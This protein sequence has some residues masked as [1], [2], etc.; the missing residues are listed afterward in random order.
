MSTPTIDLAF[1]KQ[2][3]SESHIAYQQKGSKLRGMV[4][5]KVHL[6]GTETRFPKYGKGSAGKK[7]R[8]GKIPVMNVPHD[9]VDCPIEDDYAGEWIDEADMRKTNVSEKSNATS[10]AA[11]AMGRLT[12]QYLIDALEQSAPQVIAA[13]GTAM[14]RSKIVEGVEILNDNEVPD[15]GNRF[16]L[17]TPRSWSKM[18]EIKEF[19]E[20]ETVGAMFPYLKNTEARRY[21]NT[22]FISHGMLTGKKTSTAQNIMFHTSAIGMVEGKSISQKWSWENQHDSWFLNTSMSLGAVRIDDEG[23]VVIGSD[24]TVAIA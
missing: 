4:R 14:T 23:V 15:D 3:E 10:A 16:C 1:I 11:M 20:A 19:V 18:L 5:R 22:T 2:F 6:V 8:H 24:D 21:L 9:H 12:D 13:G 17:L 7:T